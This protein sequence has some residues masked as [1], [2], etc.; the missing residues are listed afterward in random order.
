MGDDFLRSLF[1]PR[2]IAVIGVSKTPGKMGYEVLTNLVKYGFPG[3]IFPVNPKYTEIHDIRCY[4][5]VLD[6]TDEIDLAILVSPL[7]R[8]PKIMG[9]LGAK[10][11]GVVVVISG[12]RGDPTSLTIFEAAR[13]YGIRIL[14][15]S[16]MGIFYVKSRLNATLGPM[17]VKEGSIGIVTESRTLGMAMMGLATVE[18][19]GLSAVVGVGDKLDINE[20]DILEFLAGDRTT[21]SIIMHLE[22]TSNPKELIEILREV[23]LRKPVVVL[24]SMEDVRKDLNELRDLIPM[25]DDVTQS[26]DLALAL[27][28][29]D[30]EGRK[31][32][33]VTNS[34][35]AGKLVRGLLTSTGIDLFSPSENLAD[36]IRQ[37]VPE[38][39]T[40]SSNPIDITG[41]AGTDVYRGVLEVALSS[42]EVDGAMA[43]YCE[44]ALS[45]PIRFAGMISE[46]WELY[47]KPVIPVIMGGER[48]REAILRLRARGVPAYPTPCRAV[49]AVDSLVR[50][51]LFLNQ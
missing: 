22:K 6:I 33:V 45:D 3:P 9:E 13:R 25:V 23:V 46:L 20:S 14:G 47:K 1:N 48:S 30:V 42:R 43:I 10:R 34:G 49:R 8:I 19:I 12:K 39:G 31:I 51:S 41:R 36:E 24:T 35:G 17:D 11:V 32:L 44:T 5:T 15:P 50:R 21:R 16:S 26:L 2:S 18:G 29:K 40:Y 37:F 7:E 27:A 28:G 38:G 4:K